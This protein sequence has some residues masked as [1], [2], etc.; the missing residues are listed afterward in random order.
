MIRA[1]LLKHKGATTTQTDLVGDI[2]LIDWSID[3][4]IVVLVLI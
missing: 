1:V 3:F 4:I 2:C